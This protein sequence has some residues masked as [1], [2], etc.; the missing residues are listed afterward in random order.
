M[1]GIASYIIISTFIPG[2]TRYRFSVA[3]LHH[4]QFGRGAAVPSQ[5][6][7][8]RI[9]ISMKQL[10][11]FLCFICSPH[12]VQDLP[13]GTKNLKLSSGQVIE[14]PNV[15]RTMIPQRIVC[16]YQRYCEETSFTPFSSR[17]MLRVLSECSASVRKSLQGLDYFAADGAQAFDTLI[18][19]VHQVSEVGADKDNWE[20]R[21]IDVLKTAKM[22]LKG[23]YKVI[24]F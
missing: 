2:L 3:N 19:I 1:S 8:S 11:H 7:I 18:D 6:P 12:L 23:D 24:I 20:S 21:T 15:I 10:D 4:L 9:R 16:Q 22:Y 13:F 5:P 17:T 14:V